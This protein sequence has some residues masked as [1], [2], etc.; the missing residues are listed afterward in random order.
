MSKIGKNFSFLI[1]VIT[2]AVLVVFMV[3][4]ESREKA[5]LEENKAIARRHF[6]EVWSQGKLDVIN[7]IFA[8]DYV[9]HQPGSPDIHGPEGLKQFVTMGR[10]TF[11]DIQF[12]VE[13][14]IAEGNKVVTRWKITGTH[15][16]TGVRATCTGISFFRFAGVKIVERWLN[17]DDLG[18]QQQ[19]GMELKPKEVEK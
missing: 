12:T 10:T 8:T 3:G 7:E 6:E 15:K 4:C 9:G 5:K 18:M 13:D 1:P 2:F 11:P 16:P 19:L 14:Q 17:K